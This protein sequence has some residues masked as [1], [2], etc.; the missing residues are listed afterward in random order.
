MGHVWFGIKQ[1]AQQ[2]ECACTSLNPYKH[3][4]AIVHTNIKEVI[5]ITYCSSTT[6]KIII[7]LHQKPK[8]MYTLYV[9]CRLKEEKQ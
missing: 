2:K 9:E 7:P 6:L 4:A 1:K 8:Y 3:S 5:I